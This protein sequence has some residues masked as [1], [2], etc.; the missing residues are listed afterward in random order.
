MQGFE[1][2]AVNDCVGVRRPTFLGK[3]KG[4]ANCDGSINIYDRGVWTEEY[5]E[6]RGRGT[7][8]DNWHADFNCDKKVDIYDRSIWTENYTSSMGQ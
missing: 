6:D 8:R 7:V 1:K 5:V 3:A 2:T 4:D